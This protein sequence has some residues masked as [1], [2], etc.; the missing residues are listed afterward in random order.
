MVPKLKQAFRVIL[1]ICIILY[2]MYL[3]ISKSMYNFWK[4]Y[5]MKKKMIYVPDSNSACI[6]WML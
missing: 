1:E 2:F 6:S 4:F 5:L 3:K